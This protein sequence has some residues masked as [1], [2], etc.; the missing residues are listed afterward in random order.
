MLF[1]SDS[2]TITVHV[3]PS[4]SD[5]GTLTNTA[6]LSA[7][8]TADPA[9]GNNSATST[10]TVNR[11][12]DLQVTKTASPDPATAGT[13]ESFT[14]KVKNLGPSDSAGYT[15]SDPVPSGTGY[16]SSSAGCSFDSVKNERDHA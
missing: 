16:V 14:V 9:N 8:S 7:E 12:A 3:S 2:Y 15:V 1:R 13:D 4:F 11:S 6:S 10:T 5:G